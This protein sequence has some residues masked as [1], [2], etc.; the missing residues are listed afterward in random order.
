MPRGQARDDAQAKVARRQCG[1]GL[2]VLAAGRT[3]L[4]KTLWEKRELRWAKTA[5]ARMAL[6][7][8]GR[9]LLAR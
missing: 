8:V 7:F 4:W 5:P 9:P 1:M 6:R 2:R 3:T